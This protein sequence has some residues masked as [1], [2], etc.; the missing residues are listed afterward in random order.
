MQSVATYGGK[1]VNLNGMNQS[2]IVVLEMPILL[3]LKFY[4]R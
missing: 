4:G 1:V 2:H 3:G